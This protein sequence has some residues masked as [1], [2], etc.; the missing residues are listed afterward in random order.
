MSNLLAIPIFV[1]QRLAP[2]AESR[3]HVSRLDRIWNCHEKSGHP[4]RCRLDL[5]CFALQ[6]RSCATVKLLPVSMGRRCGPLIE[7]RQQPAA[8]IA[9]GW[10]SC[11]RAK[12]AGVYVAS[13]QSQRELMPLL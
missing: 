9:R 3:Q 7:P 11:D 12:D 4:H 5:P 8:F 13:G 10:A 6:K 1:F 2:V